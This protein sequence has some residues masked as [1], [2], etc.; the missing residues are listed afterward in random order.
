MT[1]GKTEQEIARNATALAQSLFG[2]MG[3]AVANPLA[4]TRVPIKRAYKIEGRVTWA[5][6]GSV[7]AGITLGLGG[8]EAKT[9]SE[10]RFTLEIEK[11]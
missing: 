6:D 2:S 4:A 5:D 11:K 10:G 3:R 8:S 9:D 7:V 1:T